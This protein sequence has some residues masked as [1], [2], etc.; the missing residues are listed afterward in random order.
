MEKDT[1]EEIE[2]ILELLRS[3]LIR[4]GVSICLKDEDI[5]FFDTEYYLE[6]RKF[7]GYKVNINDLV[8]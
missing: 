4:H 6:T 8:K 7:N 3:C 5:C 1:K 2:I